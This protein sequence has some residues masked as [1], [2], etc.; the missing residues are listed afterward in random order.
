MRVGRW[1]MI[2]GYCQ[3]IA[4]S[5]LIKS[6]NFLRMNHKTFRNLVHVPDHVTFLNQVTY[7]GTLVQTELPIE[8]KPNQITFGWTVLPSRDGPVFPQI[9]IAKGDSFDKLPFWSKVTEETLARLRGRK[10]CGGECKRWRLKLKYSSGHKTIQYQYHTESL[11]SR[12]SYPLSQ[13]QL[14]GWSCSF[15]CLSHS[16]ICYNFARK[17]MKRNFIWSVKWFWSI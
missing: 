1:A 11:P 12:T 8:R 14:L 4:K 15:R 7:S 16:Q 5:M 3:N 17:D 10:L 13:N 2:A 9:Q 6:V